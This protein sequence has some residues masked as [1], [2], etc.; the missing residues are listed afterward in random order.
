ML[1]YAYPR[2]SYSAGGNDVFVD[3]GSKREGV[4]GLLQLLGIP[5]AAAVHFGAALGRRAGL[6]TT[7]HQPGGV[8]GIARVWCRLPSRAE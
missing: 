7:F 5:P 4:R 2:S 8:P 1:P 3:C 6:K